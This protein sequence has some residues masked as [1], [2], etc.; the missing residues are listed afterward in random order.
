MDGW[1]SSHW[2]K[3]K[4]KC[5]DI[6]K[7]IT[8]EKIVS[9]IASLCL[10]GLVFSIAMTNPKVSDWQSYLPEEG[11]LPEFNYRLGHYSRIRGDFDQ[12]YLHN[13]IIKMFSQ[14]TQ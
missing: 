5:C 4:W 10:L 3:N 11:N 6:N 2:P 1:L 9:S 7:Y 8:T 12:L 13:E 14:I